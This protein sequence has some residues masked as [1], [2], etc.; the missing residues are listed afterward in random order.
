MMRPRFEDPID[1]AQD[2]VDNNITVFDF[3]GL[4]W[5]RRRTLIEFNIREGFIY[6]H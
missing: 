5:Q 4:I 1:T 6:Y 2:L 3:E